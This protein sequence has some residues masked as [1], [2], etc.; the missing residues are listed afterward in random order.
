MRVVAVAEKTINAKQMP[1]SLLHVLPQIGRLSSCLRLALFRPVSM[2]GQ[3]KTT[4]R[5]GSPLKKHNSLVYAFVSNRGEPFEGYPVIS[6]SAET[7]VS[8]P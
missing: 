2:V 4:F 1:T 5:A 3:S 8:N 7:N 6:T